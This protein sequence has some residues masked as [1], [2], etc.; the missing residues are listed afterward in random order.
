MYARI[1]KCTTLFV[2][3]L[4]VLAGGCN[5]NERLARMAQEHAAQQAEQSREMVRVQKEVAQ[6]SKQLVEADAQARREFSGLHRELQAER[7]QI[8]RQRD[9]LETDRREIAEQRHRDPIIAAAIGQIGL[10]LACLLPLIVC[11]YLLGGLRRS[12]ASD[13]MVT[14]LLVEELVAEEPRLLPPREKLPAQA[15]EAAALLPASSGT[16]A[17]HRS[18]P[19]D[20]D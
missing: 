7:S 14:E 8:G 5:E 11:I 20:T 15:D 10:I 13:E 9:A 17:A 6:G 16:V 18:A 1:A 3:V 2:F 4:A 19:D 12:E